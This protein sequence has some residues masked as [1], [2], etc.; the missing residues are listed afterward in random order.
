[1]KRGFALLFA[2]FASSIM[3]SIGLGI[4]NVIYKELILSSI[5]RESEY[6]FY[7]AESGLECALALND[8]HSGLFR[9]T[10]TDP[11][12]DKVNDNCAGL[13]ITSQGEPGFSS[14]TGIGATT[15]FR[16]L[17]PPPDPNPNNYP[18]LCANIS[19]YKSL[20]N[21]IV[22]ESRGYNTA[23]TDIVNPRRVERS[24]KFRTYISTE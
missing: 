23:C 1:M 14:E 16:I 7:A 18:A 6:S 19:V 17:L 24:L 12:P 21:Y 10:A 22:V 3:L 8:S 4:S 9:A 13:N 15:T 5:G 20:S 2:M 11:V